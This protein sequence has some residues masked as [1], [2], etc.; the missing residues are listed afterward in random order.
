MLYSMYGNLNCRTD[1]FNLYKRGG[2]CKLRCS[3]LQPVYTIYFAHTYA[4]VTASDVGWESALSVQELFD[5]VGNLHLVL[6]YALQHKPSE[7]SGAKQ[8]RNKFYAGDISFLR[9]CRPHPTIKA[10]ISYVYSVD[11][12]QNGFV[13]DIGILCLMYYSNGLL[14]TDVIASHVLEFETGMVVQLSKCSY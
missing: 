10:V 9:C 11:D 4:P 5:F 8:R 13:D 14:D 3:T 1:E 7:K 6:E 12:L 2:V